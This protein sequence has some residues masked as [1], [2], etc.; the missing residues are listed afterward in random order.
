MR[1]TKRLIA[2]GS[3]STVQRIDEEARLFGERL[4]SP[5]AAEAFTAFFEKRPPNFA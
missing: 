4:Q 2:G 5:E 3:D 1:I